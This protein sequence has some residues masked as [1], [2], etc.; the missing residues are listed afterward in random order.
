MNFTFLIRSLN[1]NIHSENKGFNYPAGCRH[2]DVWFSSFL[3]TTHDHQVTHSSHQQ[4]QLP[5]TYTGLCHTMVNEIPREN[6]SN[7][8][9]IVNNIWFLNATQRQQ[10]QQRAH[11]VDHMR[12]ESTHSQTNFPE[13]YTCTKQHGP[14]T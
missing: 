7:H 14:I 4:L 3:L 11:K 1:S 10:H 8:A 9:T 6:S 2:A 13:V 5:V 12:E